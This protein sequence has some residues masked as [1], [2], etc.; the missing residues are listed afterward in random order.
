[1]QNAML[2]L[3]Q[4]RIPLPILKPKPAVLNQVVLQRLNTLFNLTCFSAS[5]VA[6][7]KL[8]YLSHYGFGLG[9]KGSLQN[10][11]N[12]LDQAQMSDQLFIDNFQSAYHIDKS[13]SLSRREYF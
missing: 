3:S 8:I 10:V 11:F 13:K 6:V 9:Q 7:S 2:D 12:R 5:V 4:Q 1:M